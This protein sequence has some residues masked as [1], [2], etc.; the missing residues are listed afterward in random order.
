MIYNAITVE[1]GKNFSLMD[2][3]LALWVD[4]D[5][6]FDFT[7]EEAFFAALIE[8]SE[9]VNQIFPTP[10]C[11]LV[12]AVTRRDIDYGDKLV[13][14]ARNR[15][16]RKVFL[17]VRDRENLHRVFSPVESHLGTARLFPSED[18][19]KRI[20]RGF[21]G[22]Q[23]KFDDVAFTDR[24]A[25]HELHALHYKRFL[26]LCCG[27][28]HRLRLFG[29]F[30]PG[31]PTLD[32]VSMKFQE[33]YC[34][35]LHDDPDSGRL[36]GDTRPKVGDW[37]KEKNTY[38]RSGSRVL[39]NW[40]ELLNPSTAPAACRERTERRR[41][42]RL[43]YEPKNRHDVMIAYR[44]G[45]SLCVDLEVH[46]GETFRYEKRSLHCKVNL[47]KFKDGDWDWDYTDQPFL[48]LDAVSAED[49]HYYIHHRES[50]KDHLDYIRFFKRAL[51]HV[52]AEHADEMQARAALAQA[53]TDGRLANGEEA[54]T[55]IDQAVVAWRAA[56]RGKSL[57]K[58]DGSMSSAWKSL[59]DQMYMLAGDGKRQAEEVETFVHELG[60]Q[61]LRL[62]LSGGAKLIVYEAPKQ[63][64]RDDRLTPHIWV[65]CITLE[66]GKKSLK[67]KSRRWAVLPK[68]AA[69]ETTLH[70]W[71]LAE[72]WIY[73]GVG[74]L[75]FE[76]KKEMLALTNGFESQL[77]PFLTTMD[78][79]EYT[80][81]LNEW[82]GVREQILRTSKYVRNPV[83][84]V[85]IGVIYYPRSKSLHY[86][87]VGTSNA[88]AILHRQAP[89]VKAA[90]ELRAYFMRPYESQVRAGELFDGALNDRN[91][92]SLLE[93]NVSFVSSRRR[94]YLQQ[95]GQDN[96]LDGRSFKD[97]RLSAWLEGFLTSTKD[98]AKV[99]LAPGVMDQAGRCQLDTLM[100]NELPADFEPLDIAE[101]ELYANDGQTLPKY[102]AWFDI[103]ARNDVEALTKL[104]PGD[105]HRPEGTGDF[106]YSTR[107]HYETTR[108]TAREFIQEKQKGLA[109]VVPAAELPD[110][111]QP[112]EGV[113]RWYRL[114]ED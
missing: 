43:Q 49:L 45:R 25:Q 102:T 4:V 92:W 81:Q 61:P 37:I 94:V 103:T 86:L 1:C 3:E 76:R 30:Y 53:L 58:F 33:K 97:P 75:T 41:G 52:Q 89:T 2:E 57:P 110:A 34:R 39:C 5:A 64:E 98:Y 27:L 87:C 54:K 113:E 63:E 11:V 7:N 90:A 23:I 38:L 91:L 16:N 62:V 99:W 104:N 68:L 28:D 19:Q 15:E 22:S 105:P 93:V 79:A 36:I 35:F 42:F 66:H 96:R 31:P 71:P 106:G 101:I 10:R 20:F 24:M 40:H 21:N 65:H 83:I 44:E 26:L 109:R 59:L 70:E 80:D 112:P 17:L 69:S 84:A 12:M 82:K 13:N 14:E 32:F 67:E 74:V 78:G 46:H 95:E 50:R 73:E 108:A 47:S 111:P 55:I 8:H 85:P 29:E 48:C 88:H 107:H 60:Y 51:A 77:R 100:N 9:F 56:N 114:T 6:K 18:D 72:E